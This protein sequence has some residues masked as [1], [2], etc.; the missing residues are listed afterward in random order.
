MNLIDIIKEEIEKFVE[1]IDVTDIPDISLKTNAPQINRTGRFDTE[2]LNGK[3]KVL[4]TRFEPFKLY[5]YII[6]TAG[7]LIVG[8]GHYKLSSKAGTIKAA[9]ELKIDNKYKTKENF[10]MFCYLKYM[11]FEAESMFYAEIK[12]LDE[13]NKKLKKCKI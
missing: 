3:V 13:Y 11:C 6:D 12:K 7:N 4:D 8:G 9:G 5:D 1:E 2:V 10:E